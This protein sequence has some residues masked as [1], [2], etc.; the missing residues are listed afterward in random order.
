MYDDIIA[1][2]AP[3]TGGAGFEFRSVPILIVC[4]CVSALGNQELSVPIKNQ[5]DILFP[6]AP[7][8]FIHQD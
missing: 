2:L 6:S 4:G 8:L 7:E 5:E 1:P 3:H